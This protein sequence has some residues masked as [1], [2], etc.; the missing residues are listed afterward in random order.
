MMHC[1]GGR[2]TG[3]PAGPS[4]PT[5]RR[6]PLRSTLNSVIEVRHRRA[7]WASAWNTRHWHRLARRS[8]RWVLAA[9]VVVVALFGEEEVDR[10]GELLACSGSPFAS[11]DIP[12]ACT[13][14]A[15]RVEASGR[16]QSRRNRCCWCSRPRGRAG[17]T[18][19]RSP[20]LDTNGDERR[21][22]VSGCRP[23]VAEPHHPLADDRL[24]EQRSQADSRP[25]TQPRC[26]R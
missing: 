25:T 7:T 3:A 20:H 2:G 15:T 21:E 13:V 4:V 1:R 24:R 26:G 22:V 8:G 18:N 23:L 19:P 17:G 10:W 12:A 5:A 6:D 14:A 9:L 11:T 16:P